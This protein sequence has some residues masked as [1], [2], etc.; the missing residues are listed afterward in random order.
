MGSSVGENTTGVS[1]DE[2]QR[3]AR[4]LLGYLVE[5][6]NRELGLMVRSGG[7][8]NALGRV[9]GGHA[10]AGLAGAVATRLAAEGMSSSPRDLALLGDRLENRTRRIGARVITPDDDEW[11]PRLEDLIRISRPQGS[12]IDRDTDPPLC[13][14]VR[15]ESS[16]REAVERS[17]SI[18]GARAET[19]YGRHLATELAYDLVSR[20]W[21]VIS[22]GAL[23]IDAAAHRGA[24]S[25]GGVTIAVLA[26]GIDRPYPAANCGLFDQIAEQGLL[27]SE[28]PPE[29]VPFRQ[30]FLM[31]NRAIAAMSRGT[32]VVEAAL[33]SGARH[34]LGRARV[35]GRGAMAV[36]GPVGSSM[37]AG[38]HAELR[39]LGT[40]LVTSAEE[41]LEEVGEV[42]TLAMRGQG[43]VRPHDRLDPLVLRLLDGVLPRKARTAEEIGA[44]V[45]VSGQDARR[46]LPLLVLAGFAVSV[47]GG[48]RLAPTTR[49][50]KSDPHVP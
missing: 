20:D 23:G 19:A 2:V 6:G 35:L 33:R 12:T 38:C 9:L 4:I 18:V 26:C 45:G 29:A 8:V 42:G 21:A 28:W 30:R 10:S 15:G 40:R 17:V 1:P 32:V 11:P 14:W 27:I 44:A 36:P 39:E 5:P 25:G 34:T 16:V 22:G 49:D 7:P 37:S 46:G 43:D 13:L 47:E 48:Y 3:L 24:L 41:I 50:D 31:R